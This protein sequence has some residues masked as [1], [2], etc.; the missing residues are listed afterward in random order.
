MQL[1]WEPF[2]L[3][4]NMDEAGEDIMD[5]LRNKYGD[6]AVARYGGDDNPLSNAGRACTPPINFKNDRFIYPTHKAHAVMEYLKSIDAREDSNKLMRVLFRKYFEEGKNINSKEVIKAAIDE[7]ELKEPEK[8]LEAADNKELI[9]LV[10][11]KDAEF[12]HKL[13]VSGV[14]FFIM[15]RNDGGRATGFSGAQPADLLGEQL[16]EAAQE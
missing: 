15:H 16:E 2:F 3:N 6:A 13:R 10:S 7:I 1:T 12:K 9:A 8:A 5:H 11:T 4:P 14:P